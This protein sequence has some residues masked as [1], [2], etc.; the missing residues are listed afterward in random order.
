MRTKQAAI[1][2]EPIS[3]C[4]LLLLSS[5]SV[6]GEIVTVRSVFQVADLGADLCEYLHQQTNNAPKRLAINNVCW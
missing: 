2:D 5:T 3:S 1:S 6:A 4:C